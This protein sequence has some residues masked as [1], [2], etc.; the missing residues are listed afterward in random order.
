MPARLGDATTSNRLIDLVKQFLALLMLA[1][2]L[3]VGWHAMKRAERNRIVPREPLDLHEFETTRP[4]GAAF[5]P[6]PAST[7]GR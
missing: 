5:D 4:A 6:A 1:L 3:F 7:A 2:V